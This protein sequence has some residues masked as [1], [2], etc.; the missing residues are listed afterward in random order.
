MRWG[1]AGSWAGAG[2]GALHSRPDYLSTMRLSGPPELTNQRVPVSIAVPIPA[3]WTAA[4]GCS[5]AMNWYLRMASLAAAL[6]WVAPQNGN[7]AVLTYT[8]QGQPLVYPSGFIETG[9]MGSLL[10]TRPVLPGG[11]LSGATIGF[12]WT[13]DRL[14]GLT[15]QTKTL[16]SRTRADCALLFT[17]RP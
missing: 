1:L 3:V 9:W 6:V 7:A 17:R 8:Y 11:T 15:N 4:F 12:G 16:G 5:G 10:S 2:N 13:N 14:G